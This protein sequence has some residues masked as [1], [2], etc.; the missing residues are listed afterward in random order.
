[1][2]TQHDMAFRWPVATPPVRQV[3]A[4]PWVARNSAMG[5]GETPGARYNRK[6]IMESFLGRSA[7]RPKL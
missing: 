5:E 1:M 3:P 4:L 7:S 2:A 6:F